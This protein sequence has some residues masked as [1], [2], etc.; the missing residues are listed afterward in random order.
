MITFYDIIIAAVLASVITSIVW[1]AWGVHY[2][3]DAWEKT[4][5][6]S[7]DTSSIAEYLR[8]GEPKQCAEVSH[9]E[10]QASNHRDSHGETDQRS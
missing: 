5:P 6:E 4:F 8:D 7:K 9:G 3:K 10:Q 1:V 2:L